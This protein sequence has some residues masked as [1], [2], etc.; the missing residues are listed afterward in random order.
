MNRIQPARFALIILFSLGLASCQSGTDKVADTGSEVPT[1][2]TA[3]AANNKPTLP[4]GAPQSSSGKP[5]APIS[6]RYEIEGTPIVGQPVAIKIFVTS[7]VTDAPISVFYRVHDASSMLFPDS[8]T[9]RRVFSKADRD[10]LRSQK[11][12][13]SGSLCS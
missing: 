8:Q 9:Q 10:E 7:S 11:I 6:F 1:E 13:M 4:A 5:S 2:K 12:S 3:T